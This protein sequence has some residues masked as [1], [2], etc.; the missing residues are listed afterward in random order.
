MHYFFNSCII[1]L[2]IYPEITCRFLL[3]LLLANCVENTRRSYCYAC[4]FRRVGEQN[5]CNLPEVD[6]MASTTDSEGKIR[7]DRRN[8][9]NYPYLILGVIALFLGGA[10]EVVPIDGIIIYS[11]AL[12]IP[13]DTARHF[14]TYTLF[15]MLFGY[16]MVSILVPK[17]ISQQKALLFAAVWGIIFTIATYLSTG[18]NSVYC[19]L[20]LSF[21][22]SMLWGTI[23]GLALRGLGGHTK[24]GSAFL[25]MS[26]VGG[27]VVTVI[28]GNLLDTY[29]DRPQVSVLILLPCYL[30]ILYYALK[31]YRAEFWA[32][33]LETTGN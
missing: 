9:F 24:K 4:V 1:F 11:R 10:C 19:M 15:I 20:F 2:R 30:F 26:I 12:D 7:K 3:V 21:S 27:G 22:A 25:I 14:S 33:I 28:F 17:C 32:R 8:A 13:M 5:N 31:G 18:L 6:E 23:W 29:V 16:L